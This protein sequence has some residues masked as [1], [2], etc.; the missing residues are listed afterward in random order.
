MQSEPS[1]P[2]FFLVSVLYHF[3]FNDEG[4]SHCVKATPVCFHAQVIQIL[5]PPRGYV[6]C[7]AGRGLPTQMGANIF[8][9]AILKVNDF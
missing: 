8:I 2:S 5:F 3:Q 7:A 9:V 4:N 6:S 1:P